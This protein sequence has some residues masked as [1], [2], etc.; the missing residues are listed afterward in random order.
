MGYSRKHRAV[1]AV[2]GDK[3]SEIFAETYEQYGL[4]TFSGPGHT[5]YAV[6]TDDEAD[7]AV[8][9]SIKGSVWAFNANFLADQTDLPFEVFEALQRDMS[10]D[11]NDAIL[12]LIER[13]DDEFDGFVNQAV[14]YDGRGHFLAGYDGYEHDVVI[15]GETFY[16]Y[17]VN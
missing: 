6:G 5:E 10:E 1:A 14:S 12:R 4:E 11:A 9:E 3:P 2:S 8:T 15:D 13:S 17:R 7:E 16:V